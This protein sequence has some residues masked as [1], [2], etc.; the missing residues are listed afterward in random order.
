MPARGRLVSINVSR[1]G[2]PKLPVPAA[3]VSAD[4]VAGDRQRDLRF[5][6]GPERAVS[7]YALE[8]IEALAREGHPIAIG[9][10]GE[11]LTV[12]GLDWREVVP[13]VGLVVGPAR[14]VV[15]SYASPCRFIAASFAQG[16]FERMSQKLHPGWSRVYA[17][18]VAGGPIAVGD[19]V[20]IA[21]A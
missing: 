12:S 17:R 9:T 20:E 8:A 15:T 16:G 14:L 18:V 1:G 5:H 2:V 19:A 3:A 7:L 13:G 4:G 10:T 21:G 6:G 11:N